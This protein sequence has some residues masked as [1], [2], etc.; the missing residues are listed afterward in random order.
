MLAI[1][2]V[3]LAA[4]VAI[5]VWFDHD[6]RLAREAISHSQIAQ[7]SVGPIEFA[8]QGAGLPVLSIHGAGGGF[9]QGLSFASDLLGTGYHVIAPSRFGYLR[10]P[11]PADASPA[12][13][14]EAHLALLDQL[15]IDKA[16]VIGVSA[17][18]RSAIELA[19]RHPDRVRAL[20]LI[21]PG[22]YAPDIPPIET[23]RSADF[24]LVLWM[25]QAGADFGWW[26]IAHA[27]PATLVRFVGV[28]P[29]LIASLPEADRDVVY[30]L[31][32]GVE[33]VSARYAGITVDGAPNLTPLPLEQI[34]APTFI[35]TA[36]DDLFSTLKP[37]EY[38]AAHIQGA[39]L[40]VYDTG[41]HILVGHGDE[42]KRLVAEFLAKAGVGISADAS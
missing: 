29:D 41:G 34:T 21:V 8:E 2:L 11:V 10:T 6:L 18:A 3:L 22:T 42:M 38:A 5:F 1:V 39:K 23:T 17:G 25:L 28:P 12:A 30:G 13:Q 4:G 40:V 37:A 24:P 9:D 20:L 7:T 33:P 27:S 19:V 26:A 35:A 36:R 14:A 16:I 15:G 31:I 32:R